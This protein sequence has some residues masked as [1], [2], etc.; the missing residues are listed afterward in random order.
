VKER[1]AVIFDLDGTLVDSAPDIATALNKALA[2]DGLPPLALPEVKAMVGSG[3]RR[4][5]ER[6]L[7]AKASADVSVETT[8][9]E[10]LEAYRARPAHDTRLYAGALEL[11]ETLHRDG[12]RLGIATNKPTD[13]THAIVNALGVLKLFRAVTGSAP[14][15]ALKPEPDLLRTCLTEL[16]VVP[17]AAV[18]VGDSGADAGAAKAAGMRCVLVRHGYSAEAVDGLGA[19]AVIDG[20]GDMEAVRA[21]LLKP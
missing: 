14:G 7:G 18:M 19:D 16:G 6:A 11:L 15:V 4:L 8:L 13:L 3:A 17:Q 12:V 1:R 5:V 10:F 21:L 2:K 20:F 9:R